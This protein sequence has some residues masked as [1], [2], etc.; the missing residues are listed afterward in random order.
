[1]SDSGI[2]RTEEVADVLTEIASGALREWHIK[3]NDRCEIVGINGRPLE[4]ADPDGS[5]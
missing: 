4:G 3:V 2:I 5:E 1:M